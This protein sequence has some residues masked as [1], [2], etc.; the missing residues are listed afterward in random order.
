[1]RENRPYGSEGG[2]AELNR[3]SLPLSKRP[4]RRP[5]RTKPERQ[6]LAGNARCG[7]MKLRDKLFLTP[8]K[9]RFMATGFGRSVFN[10]PFSSREV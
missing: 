7:K 6:G 5:P 1:M 4:S 8:G 2:G 9:L 10:R 3:L